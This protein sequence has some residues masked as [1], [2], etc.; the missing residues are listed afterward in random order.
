MPV[1]RR[2]TLDHVIW[3]SVAG[4]YPATP[5]SFAA[6]DLVLDIGC[7]TGA[8]CA[9][10][11]RRGASVV[12]YEAGQANYALA[13]INTTQL[14]SVRIRWAAVWRS[15]R[16]PGRLRF[17]PFP[18][19]ANTGGGSV[20]F[21]DPN[22]HRRHALLWGLTAAAATDSA[23]A[24]PGPHDVPSVGLDAILGELGRVRVLKLDIEGAE[25]PVLATATMLHRVDLIVGEYHEFTEAQMD[26]LAP[27]ARVGPDRYG[28]ELL[29]RIL[30]SAGFAA[31]LRP[32]SPRDGQF[33]A[34]RR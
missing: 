20:L 4:E 19:P 10:A 8:F 34:V 11:A 1:L 14:A 3:Q 31:T 28:G 5:R 2:N 33:T 15:D 30:A 22:Q 12:G 17:V 18:E 21:T 6:A 7:H 32:V 9:L 29:L 24:D 16:A 27:E 23:P 26:N 13:C 25:F